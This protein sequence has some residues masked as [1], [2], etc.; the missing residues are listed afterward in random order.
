MSPPHAE[1]C[2]VTACKSHA[3]QQGRAMVARRQEA[4]RPRRASSSHSTTD[5]VG[6]RLHD[7]PATGSTNGST[8]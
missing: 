7:M 8:A 6:D 1:G 3:K 2:A 4:Q 5:A